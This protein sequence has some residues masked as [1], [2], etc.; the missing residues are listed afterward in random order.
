MDIGAL[1]TSP[2]KGEVGAPAP[3]GGNAARSEFVSSRFDQFKHA[4]EILR[5]IIVPK[6]KLGHTA[7]TQPSSAPL[8]P[9]L[10]SAFGVLAAVKL[11]RQTQLRAI[12]IEDIGPN[13]MLPPKAQSVETPAS[14]FAP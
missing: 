13:G 10:L 8:I 6:S 2:C 3:G 9:N 11:D 12:K 7:S 5:D 1:L 14:Q 4:G